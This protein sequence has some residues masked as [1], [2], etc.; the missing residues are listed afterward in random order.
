[1][2]LEYAVPLSVVA[3]IREAVVVVV[4]DKKSLEDTYLRLRRRSRRRYVSGRAF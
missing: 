4:I 2:V 1:M 3:A